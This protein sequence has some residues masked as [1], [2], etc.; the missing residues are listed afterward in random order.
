V[1][2]VEDQPRHH[3]LQW[4]PDWARNCWGET[5]SKGVRLYHTAKSRDRRHGRQEFSSEDKAIRE[6]GESANV[7]RTE[8]TTLPYRLMQ[9]HRTHRRATGRSLRQSLDRWD[10]RQGRNGKY[11]EK[12]RL[13]KHRYG[14]CWIAHVATEQDVGQFCKQNRSTKISKW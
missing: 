2:P 4:V 9:R 8:T 14:G 6:A 10:I 5:W 1:G 13:E 3:H 12:S 11:K 7:R